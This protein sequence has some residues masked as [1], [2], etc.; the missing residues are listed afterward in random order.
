MP[1][2]ETV[3]K[4]FEEQLLCKQPSLKFRELQSVCEFKDKVDQSG[5]YFDVIILDETYKKSLAGKS[6]EELLCMADVLANAEFKLIRKLAFE[7]LV[8]ERDAQNEKAKNDLL[9]GIDG[10]K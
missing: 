6:D 4:H 9:G 10:R 3:K 2:D 7:S 8:K 5:K 1:I